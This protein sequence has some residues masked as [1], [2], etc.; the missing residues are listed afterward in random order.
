MKKTHT[1]VCISIIVGI[2]S[3][4]TIACLIDYPVQTY[5]NS[6]VVAGERRTSLNLVS[7]H[8]SAPHYLRLKCNGRTYNNVEGFEPFYL[9]V[10][11]LHSILFVTVSSQGMQTVHI[12]NLETLKEINIDSAKH[13]FG[14]HIGSGRAP[15][16]DLTDWVDR[17]EP[18]K[19]VVAARSGNRTIF[20]SLNLTDRK[21]ERVDDVLS[22]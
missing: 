1:I 2:L 7:V 13:Y 15:G 8:S 5:E 11:E 14:G 12:V 17:V 10:P 4:L 18:G 19:V 3:I 22:K 16:D 6:Y 20:I 9:N 21:L